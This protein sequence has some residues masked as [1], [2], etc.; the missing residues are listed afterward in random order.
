MT[1]RRARA[2][3]YTRISRDPEGLRLG[4]ERQDEDCRRLAERQNLDVV[5]TFPDNDISASTLSKKSR[6]QFTAM[7]EG[8]RRG[9]FGVIVAYS[10]SRLTRRLLELN[11]LIELHRAHG[12]RIVTVV[13]GEDDLSTA[14]GRMIANIKASVDQA[15]AERLSERSRRAHTQRAANGRTNK[16][17]RAFGWDADKLHLHPVEADLLRAAA[18]D[19]VDG[20]PLRAIV[21]DWTDR[22]ILTPYGK[23]WTHTTLRRTLQKPRLVGVQTHHG[24]VLLDGTGEPVRGEWEPLLDRDAFDRLQ[25]ALARGVRGGGRPGSRRY[26]LTGIMRCAVCG[27]RMNGMKT[28]KSYAYTCQGEPRTHTTTIAG[29]QTDELI[30]ELA[31]RRLESETLEEPEPEQPTAGRME[32]IPGLIAE[33][34]EAFNAGRLSGAIAFPQ[35]EAL[36]AEREQLRAE[37]ARFITVTSGPMNVDTSTLADM[38]VDRQRAVL[39]QLFDA[40]VVAP[41]GHRG[42]KWNPDRLT[43]V[44]RTA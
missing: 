21:R 4:V 41:V 32:Q 20:V 36:E 8:A 18:R 16:G 13:S 28:P 37:R 22:G 40:I 33:L 42:G 19:V 25:A 7:M 11:D 3:I 24:E 38:D 30:L 26:L 31:R 39:A 44:W 34:M 29:R 23:P 9:E 43:V 10:N 35:V 6:P 15:E 27:A 17:V 1:E 5:A 2:A 12:T 14:D